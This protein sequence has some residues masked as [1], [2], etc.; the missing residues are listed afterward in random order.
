MR[1]A[2]AA[3]RSRGK[4]GADRAQRPGQDG[5]GGRPLSPRPG[6]G[7]GAAVWRGAGWSPDQLP[8]A[9]ALTGAKADEREILL[10]MFTTEPW[11]PPGPG[12]S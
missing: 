2:S 12:R 9:F 7:R 4:P 5:G 11:S 1:S 10:A 6:S 8:V 3:A